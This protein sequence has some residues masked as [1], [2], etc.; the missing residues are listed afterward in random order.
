VNP[1]EGDQ[2]DNSESPSGIGYEEIVQAPAI[3]DGRF[4]TEGGGSAV[5]YKYLPGSSGGIQIVIEN[6]GS[7]GTGRQS[8]R[9]VR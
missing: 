2:D 9:Q 3:G 8:W 5:Q 7:G 6:P 1:A 4:G